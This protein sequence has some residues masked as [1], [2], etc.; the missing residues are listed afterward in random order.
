MFVELN[1]QP[2]PN[3]A[4]EADDRSN[5]DC[6]GSGNDQERGKSS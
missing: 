4:I 6:R 3:N 2:A 1:D 5:E